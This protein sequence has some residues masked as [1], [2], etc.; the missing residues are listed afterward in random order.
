MGRASV[1]AATAHQIDLD[2]PRTRAQWMN[3]S[4]RASLRRILRAYAVHDPVV[5][6]CQGM[7]DI[8]AVFVILGFDESAS[9]HGLWAMINSCCPDYFCPALKGY[10]RDVSVLQELVGDVLSPEVGRMLTG[11]D[12]P[13]HA[14]AAD[15]FLALASH[16]WPLH[17]VV[18]L[19]DL[20]LSEGSPAVFA[21]FIALL[22]LYLPKSVKSCT[23][24]PDQFEVFT[25]AVWKG[26]SEELDTILEQTRTLIR[27][28]PGSRLH[29][30]RSAY[31]Q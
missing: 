8:A 20:F 3:A 14:L 6:Y 1:P 7:S 30:L 16:T 26:V 19:W 12:V 27:C 24:G 28:I 2:V 4:Q 31:A 10:V 25:K 13:L 29:S 5:G 9:L 21:S 17:A 22:Q 15:H 11:L 23:D 18:R